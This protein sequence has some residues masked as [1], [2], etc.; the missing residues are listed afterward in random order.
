MSQFKTFLWTVN[1][2]LIN[3]VKSPNKNSIMDP[4][5]FGPVIHITMV[6]ADLY[7]TITS[8]CQNM[9]TNGDVEMD[10]GVLVGRG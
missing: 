2:D 3:K 6:N 7:I 8:H 4:E 10:P 5:F 9:Q 1:K